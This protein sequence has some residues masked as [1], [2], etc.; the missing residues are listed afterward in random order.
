V[1]R[2]VPRASAAAAVMQ[3]AARRASGAGANT[4]AV[5]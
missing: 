4:L 1:P 2:D 5:M 3:V